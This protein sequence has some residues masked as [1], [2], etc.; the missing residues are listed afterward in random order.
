[1]L[2]INLDG[3]SRISEQFFITD[4]GIFF[5]DGIAFRLMQQHFISENRPRKASDEPCEPNYTVMTD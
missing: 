2:N 5:K 3:N 4:Y 1:M